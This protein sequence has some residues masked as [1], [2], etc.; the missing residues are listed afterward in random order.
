VK[1]VV[2][3]F[4]AGG[5]EQLAD[6]QIIITRPD[7][8]G[9]LLPRIPI[10]GTFFF[11]AKLSFAADEITQPHTVRVECTKPN[12]ARVPIGGSGLTLVPNPQNPAADTTTMTIGVI[13]L[14]FEATG[15]Y[16]FHLIVDNVE[17]LI[18]SLN[19]MQF[20]QG[21]PPVTMVG[22]GS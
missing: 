18:R 7:M 4:L 15:L 11:I 8:D 5:V 17:T 1:D 16:Q 10:Q 20:P 2:F 19:V 21:T 14:N 3:G 12:G 9:L 6:G 22:E 13:A